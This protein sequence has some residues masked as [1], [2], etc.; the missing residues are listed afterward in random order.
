MELLKKKICKQVVLMSY[1][2]NV[3]QFILLYQIITE[4]ILRIVLCNMQPCTN[5]NTLCHKIELLY[6]FVEFNI[7]QK[8]FHHRVEAYSAVFIC[9]LT[10]YS[11]NNK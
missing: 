6:I 8:Y 10:T 7:L 2:F 11:P 3:I 4:N 5:L 9:K 1:S